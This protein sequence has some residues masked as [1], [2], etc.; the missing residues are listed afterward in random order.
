MT[1]IYAFLVDQFILDA[2][3][4]PLEMFGVCVIFFVTVSVAV[5]KLKYPVPEVK[6]VE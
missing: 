1:I 5:Y 6:K 3:V 2:V 4:A